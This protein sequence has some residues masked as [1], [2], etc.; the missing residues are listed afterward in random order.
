MRRIDALKIIHAHR[1]DQ[2]MIIGVGYQGAEIYS[3]GHSDLNLRSVNLPY[4]AP[5]GL[6]LAL[7]LPHQKIIVSEGDGSAISGMSSWCTIASMRPK[8]FIH[9]IWDNGAWMANGHFK[10]GHFGPIP[11]SSGRGA[12]LVAIAKGAGIS[13]AFAIETEQELDAIFRRALTEDGP[14]ILVVKVDTST[15]E[16]L[17]PFPYSCLES[18]LRFRRALI[19]KGWVSPWHAG[20]TLFKDTPFQFLTDENTSSIAA[21]YQILKGIMPAKA[22]RLSVDYARTI[23]SSLRNAGIDTVVYLPDSSN[24]LVQRFAAEDPVITSVCVTQ[25]DEGMAIAMGAFM[26]GKTPCL[27]MEA[28]GLGLCNLALAWLG[29]QMR[30]ATLILTSHTDGLGEYTD[31]HVCTRYVVEGPLRSMNIP[32]YTMMDIRDAGRLIKQATMTIRGQVTPVAIQLPRHV[33]WEDPE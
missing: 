19:D 26:G 23:Y 7:A 17:P 6:G 32:H 13:N 31:Y 12:D 30:L 1:T 33:L 3:L 4:P 16:S 18:S 21:T 25:E 28:S 24:Y 14:F 20:A 5:M 9:I 29:I 8:N 27:I 22:P 10:G 11:T 2:P 15:L